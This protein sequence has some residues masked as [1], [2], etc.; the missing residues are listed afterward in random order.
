MLCLILCL[1]TLNAKGQRLFL[2]KEKKLPPITEKSIT[3]TASD[4]ASYDTLVDDYIRMNNELLELQE[5]L[6]AEVAK[7]KQLSQS[8]EHCILTHKKAKRRLFWGSVGRTIKD[9]SI[10]IGIGFLSGKIL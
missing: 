5:K 4:S 2:G 8:L 7:T 10:G 6:E 3:E 1:F 9:V